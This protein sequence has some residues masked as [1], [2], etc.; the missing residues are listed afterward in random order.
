MPTTPQETLNRA[1]EELEVYYKELNSTE[2]SEQANAEKLD[3]EQ[4]D[5]ERVLKKILFDAVYRGKWF[6]NFIQMFFNCEVEIVEK[7]VGQIGF[8]VQ[9][10]RWIVERTFS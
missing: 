8:V 3:A 2:R 10:K 5:R 9:A 7:L 6:S 4:L 1:Q